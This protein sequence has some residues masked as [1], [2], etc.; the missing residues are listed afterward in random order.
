[1]AITEHAARELRRIEL[2]EELEALN[3]GLAASRR[4]LAADFHPLDARDRLAHPV[5]HPLPV[6]MRQ[7]NRINQLANGLTQNSADRHRHEPNYAAEER[8]GEYLRS[9]RNSVVAAV[10]DQPNEWR[11]AFA[12]GDEGLSKRERETRLPLMETAAGQ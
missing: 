11:G 5:N 7:G 2:T 6:V 4:R 9:R 8:R 12:G 10:A 3:A 1:M